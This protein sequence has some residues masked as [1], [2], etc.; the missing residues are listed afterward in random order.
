[1]LQEDLPDD[2]SDVNVVPMAT[3][4]SEASTVSLTR[5][6]DMSSVSLSASSEDDSIKNEKSW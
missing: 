3:T 1:M 2:A 4:P 6:V 5:T